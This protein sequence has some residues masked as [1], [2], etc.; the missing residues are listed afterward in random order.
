[1]NT[2]TKAQARIVEDKAAG[3]RAVAMPDSERWGVVMEVQEALDGLA[4]MI[5]LLADHD[6]PVPHQVMAIIRALSFRLDRPLEGSY[7]G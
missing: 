7:F 1:M 4:E 6:E 3:M 2:A 5:A